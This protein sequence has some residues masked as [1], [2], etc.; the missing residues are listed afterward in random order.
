MDVL[1]SDDCWV[2]WLVSNKQSKELVAL[3][4]FAKNDDGQIEKRMLQ[5]L[6]FYKL[7]FEDTEYDYQNKFVPIKYIKRL[8]KY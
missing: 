3:K 5:E 8:P 1:Q 4:Q 2:T 7:I 6:W